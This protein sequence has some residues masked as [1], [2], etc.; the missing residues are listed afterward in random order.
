M[1]PNPHRNRGPQGPVSRLASLIT[2]FAVVLLGGSSIAQTTG[3]PFINDYTIDTFGSGQPSCFSHCVSQ[4]ST[5]V[6]DVSTAPGN[7]VMF[8]IAD[9][10]CAAGS[11][12]WLTNSCAPAIPLSACGST[13]NQSIDLDLG[14]NTFILLAPA[15]FGNATV[16]VAIPNLSI[17]PCSMNWSTQAVVFDTCGLG[18]PPFGPFV[19][20]QAFD[21]V[22]G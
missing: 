19:L 21:L 13:T 10:A 17:L 5:M 9:C 11:A 12:C 20:T 22:I 16:T 1:S 18:G 14:C 8:V 15:T 4:N 3:E 7:F 2:G 6:L